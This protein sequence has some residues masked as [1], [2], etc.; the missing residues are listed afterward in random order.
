MPHTI[1]VVFGTRP[2]AI[3]MGPVLRALRARDVPTALLCTGQH[4]ELDLPGCNVGRAPDGV[5]AFDRVPSAAGPGGPG[6]VRC[7]A[8]LSAGPVELPPHD[9]VLLSSGPLTDGGQLPPDTTA[10]LRI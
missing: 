2:E 8:N 5:L 9:A 10:W 4:R 1:L 3:K 6:G 7:V